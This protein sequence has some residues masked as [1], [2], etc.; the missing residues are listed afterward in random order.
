[1][2][3]VRTMNEHGWSYFPSHGE[4]RE[5]FW[6]VFYHCL[7]TISE[8]QKQSIEVARLTGLFLANGFM[9]DEHGDMHPA[10]EESLDLRYLGAVVLT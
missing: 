4:L 7:G 8:A 6:T 9:Q 10:T 3:G 5:Q 1:M 2:L